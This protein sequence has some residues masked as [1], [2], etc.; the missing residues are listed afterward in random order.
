MTTH[1]DMLTER[2]AA[3]SLNVTAIV[4]Q[5]WRRTGKGPAY[6]KYGTSRQARVRYR[7]SDIEAFKAECTVN[8]RGA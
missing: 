4:M 6:I 1:K 7:L 3:Q 5:R 8:P 2:E